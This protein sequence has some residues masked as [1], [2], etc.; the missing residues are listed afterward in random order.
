MSDLMLACQ[1]VVKDFGGVRALAGVNTTVSQ[2]EILGLVGPNGS[3]KS[4][5]INVITGLHEPT[6]GRLIF[7]GRDITDDE[8]HL[9]TQLGI[10]RTYQVPR[11]FSTMTVL[12]NVMVSATFGH[13]NL[14]L[15]RARVDAREALEFTGLAAYA[16]APVGKLNLHQRKFLELARALSTKPQLLLL[17][18]VM[19]GLNPTEIDESVAM[20]RKVYESGVTMV[21]VEHLMRVVTSLSTRMI[22]LNY[23]EVIADGQPEQVMRDPEVIIAYLGKDYA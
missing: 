3:G 9:I 11:P 19:A 10:A 2:G 1:N 5:L 17:D 4:T 12:E 20:I 23:G 14:G 18:E 7:Q 13:S 6:G 8:P 15:D 16:E 22:I 21:I